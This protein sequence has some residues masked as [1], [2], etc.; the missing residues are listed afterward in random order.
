MAVNFISHS[1]SD[2]LI[3]LWLPF[4]PTPASFIYQLY[5]MYSNLSG[6]MLSHVVLILQLI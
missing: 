4:L 5:I 3:V 1:H 6:Y 2:S